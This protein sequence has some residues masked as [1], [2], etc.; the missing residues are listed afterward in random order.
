L[1]LARKR[2]FEGR[3]LAILEPRD[4]RSERGTSSGWALASAIV[5]LAFPLAALAPIEPTGA[6]GA[7]AGESGAGETVAT[8]VRS[9]DVGRSG[10]GLADQIRE[11]L[12]EEANENRTRDSSASELDASVGLRRETS[13]DRGTVDDR[14]R[15]RSDDW[16]SAVAGD[17][18]AAF[19]EVGGAIG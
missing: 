1:P 14:S 5:V 12:A 8:V 2:E 9:E 4:E 18:A 13:T 6:D 16:V 15:S 17:V 10:S 11:M 3:I 19:A 7:V